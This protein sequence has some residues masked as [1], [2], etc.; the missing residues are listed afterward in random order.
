MLKSARA[1]KLDDAIHIFGL[2]ETL[3]S[4]SL[5]GEEWAVLRSLWIMALPT[6]GTKKEAE[7]EVGRM[8]FVCRGSEEI[9]IIVQPITGFG[10]FAYSVLV[11]FGHVPYRVTEKTHLSSQLDDDAESGAS[12]VLPCCLIVSAKPAFG[13]DFQNPKATSP[14]ALSIHILDAPMNDQKIIAGGRLREV[15]EPYLPVST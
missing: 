8:C 12:R 2:C 15:S 10:V 14:S 3:G 7:Q 1:P 9:S 4:R 13:D 5:S 11:L 6:V